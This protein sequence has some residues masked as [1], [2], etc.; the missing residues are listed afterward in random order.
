MMLVAVVDT[1]VV[2]SGLLTRDSRAPAARI[3][4]GML[5]GRLHFLLSDPLLAEYRAVL[6]APA[7]ARRHGLGA[8]DVDRVLEGVVV[9][10]VWRACAAT[11]RGDAHVAA[12]L[13]AEERARLITGDAA[14]LRATLRGG[15]PA[16]TPA[17]FC[18]LAW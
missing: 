12:L 13:R 8:D 6:L 4:D 15:R 16:H 7:V 2:V 1:D 5:A 11:A 9:N 14:V 17:E 3:L 18:R 10:A